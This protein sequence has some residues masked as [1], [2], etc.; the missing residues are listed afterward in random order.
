MKTSRRFRSLTVIL[1]LWMLLFSQGALAA[2]ICKGLPAPAP[3]SVMEMPDGMPCSE[4]V[5]ADDDPSGDDIAL[6]HAHCQSDDQSADSFQPP[7]LARFDDLAAG[8][9]VALASTT[10]HDLAGPQPP[11]L[12]RGA[13]PPLAVQHCCLRI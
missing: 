2:Y 8:L 6:C 3:A 1:S 10:T 9:T 11:L 4:G 7:S 5:Q 13:A 12:R